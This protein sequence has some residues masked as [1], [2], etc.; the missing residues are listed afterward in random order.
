MEA[1]HRRVVIL[2]VGVVSVFLPGAD[3]YSTGSLNEPEVCGHLLPVHDNGV[4]QVSN[5]PYEF[6][7][8]GMPGNGSHDATQNLTGV[9]NFI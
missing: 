7:V 3:G 4:L 1:K 6:L 8:N 5:S 2:V 9:S